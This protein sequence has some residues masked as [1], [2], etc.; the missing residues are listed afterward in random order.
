MTVVSISD[1]AR[2]ADVTRSTIYDRINSGVLSRTPEGIDVAELAR[3]YP[4]LRPLENVK[5][6]HV[7]KRDKGGVD[8]KEVSS[9]LLDER[10]RE[11]EYLQTEL[12]KRTE[13]IAKKDAQLQQANDRLYEKDENWQQRLD[14][15]R[16]DFQRLLEAPQKRKKIFGIF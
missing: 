5:I 7:K 2:L 12:N 10:L 1:A 14:A 15:M 16:S 6:K 13:Q 8:R 3:V 11:I 9:E 4:D